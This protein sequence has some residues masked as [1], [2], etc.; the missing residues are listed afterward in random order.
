MVNG[1]PPFIASTDFRRSA[2]DHIFFSQLSLIVFTPVVDDVPRFAYRMPPSALQDLPFPVLADVFSSYPS[3]A[4]TV[5]N[6]E[7]AH[8]KILTPSHPTP[9][10]VQRLV[11]VFSENYR[12]HF[13]KYFDDQFCY[14]DGV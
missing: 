14:V 8:F 11:A 6:G 13:A 2:S 1:L 9:C 4:R 3:D 7:R 10:F 12:A 5:T